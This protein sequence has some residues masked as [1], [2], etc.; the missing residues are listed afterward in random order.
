MSALEVL[1]HLHC[2]LTIV[3]SSALFYLSTLCR[4]MF[5]CS[6]VRNVL[7]WLLSLSLQ[8]AGA[9]SAMRPGWRMGNGVFSCRPSGWAGT[10]ARRPAVQE[11]DLWL[12][13]AAWRFR[14]I[15]Y[16]LFPVLTIYSAG[17]KQYETSYWASFIVN[18]NDVLFS[19]LFSRRWGS[20]NTGSGCHETKAH[21]P[22]STTLYCKRGESRRMSKRTFVFFVGFLWL[23][24]S[25]S[26]FYL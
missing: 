21:G 13:S 19:R 17:D 6:D 18:V 9:H 25:V 5:L 2:Y 24:I 3:S 1:L 22:G 11:E 8:P 7:L 4:V 15:W 26:M 20:C 10:G 12:L 23:I 16:T 14:Y